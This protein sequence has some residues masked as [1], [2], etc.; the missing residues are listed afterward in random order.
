MYDSPLSVLTVYVSPLS[1]LQGVKPLP[2]ELL[3]PSYHRWTARRGC[4]RT[5]GTICWLLMSMLQ[6]FV[7]LN[8]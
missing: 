8:P 1:A 7:L 2:Q 5:P 4:V 6:T 3:L